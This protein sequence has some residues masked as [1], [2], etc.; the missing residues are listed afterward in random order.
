[1]SYPN[2]EFLDIDTCS[3]AELREAVKAIL[4]HFNLRIKAGYWPD[5]GHEFNAVSKDGDKS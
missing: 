5:G 2:E 4:E 3:E 1:M